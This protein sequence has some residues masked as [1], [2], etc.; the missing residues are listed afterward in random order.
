MSPFEPII[1]L[2]ICQV[3]APIAVGI[4]SIFYGSLTVLALTGLKK[5]PEIIS[6]FKFV[7]ISS[8]TSGAST[9]LVIGTLRGGFDTELWVATAINIA[10]TFG[11]LEFTNWG[12]EQE[13][14]CKK[15]LN[16]FWDEVRNRFTP[17]R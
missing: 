16:D 17:W 10:L 6:K 3:L 4:H 14:D 9:G 15:K 2:Y 7:G 13:Q 5:T 12:K 1:P 11:L 8:L